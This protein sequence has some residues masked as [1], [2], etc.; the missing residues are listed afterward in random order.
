MTNSQDERANIRTRGGIVMRSTGRCKLCWQ[1]RLYLTPA[2]GKAKVT[3]RTRIDENMQLIPQP[4]KS[5]F[6]LSGHART[7]AHKGP[8]D[9]NATWTTRTLNM[10]EKTFNQ[11]GESIGEAPFALSHQQSGHPTRSQPII[12]L[13]D[14]PLTRSRSGARSHARSGVILVFVVVLLVLLAIM[15]TAYL[16]VV[17]MDRLQ[18]TGRGA[19]AN[20]NGLV[21]ATVLNQI[22]ERAKTLTLETLVR[23][24][25]AQAWNPNSTALTLDARYWRAPMNTPSLPV[26]YF[27]YVSPGT[28]SPWLS[29]ILP[30]VTGTGTTAAPYWRFIGSPVQRRDTSQNLLVDG[31]FSD[32]R[33]APG[34][35]APSTPSFAVTPSSPVTAYFGS[36]AANPNPA[37]VIGSVSLRNTAGTGPN[38]NRTYPAFA[39]SGTASGVPTGS[40]GVPF[41]AADADGDGIADSGLAP[42][43]LNPSGTTFVERYVAAAVATPA[44]S[45]AILDPANPGVAYYVGV[46]VVDNSAQINVQT[47]LSATSDVALGSTDPLVSLRTTG[48]LQ[49]LPNYGFFRSN[50]GFIELLESLDR[51]LELPLP[52]GTL[53]RYATAGPRIIDQSGLL[54]FRLGQFANPGS[55]WNNARTS[56]NAPW[57]ESTVPLP[58]KITNVGRQSLGDVLEQTSAS[59]LASPG[60]YV[61]AG[62]LQRVGLFDG[63]SAGASLAYRAGLISKSAVFGAIESVLIESTRFAAANFGG[64]APAVFD[65]FPANEVRLWFQ[66]SKNFPTNPAF[67]SVNPTVLNYSNTPNDYSGGAPGDKYLRSIR[68]LLTG[69]SGVTNFAPMRS[70]SA[71]TPGNPVSYT[72]PAFAASYVVPA[73]WTPANGPLAYPPMRV[74]V[75]VGSFQQLYRAFWQAMSDPINASL[76]VVV[77]PGETTFLSNSRRDV[78]ETRTVDDI[79]AEMLQLRTTIAALNTLDLRPEVRTAPGANPA[80]DPSVVAPGATIG[81]LSL[82]G[83]RT[84]A[85]FGNERQPFIIRVLMDVDLTAAPT[86]TVSRFAVVLYNPYD[87]DID[88]ATGDYKLLSVTRST[89]NVTLSTE[90]IA[91]TGNLAPRSLRVLGI[92]GTPGVAVTD[93]IATPP[94]TDSEIVLVRS[95]VTGVPM[96]GTVI[97]N[98]SQPNGPVPLDVVDLRRVG[99]NVVAQLAVLPTPPAYVRYQYKRQVAALNSPDRFT[100]VYAGDML[101]ANAAN[102][103]TTLFNLSTSATPF[104]DET[105]LA[106]A[107]T[108]GSVPPVNIPLQVF[109]PDFTGPTF[110]PSTGLGARFPFNVFPYK[111]PF[112]RDADLSAIPYIGSFIIYEAGGVIADFGTITTDAWYCDTLVTTGN[113][114]TKIAVGR[115]VQ[116]PG[117]T[118]TKEWVRALTESLTAVQDPVGD[119][120]PNTLVFNDV[121]GI[122]PF[123]SSFNPNASENQRIAGKININT[124]PAAVLA[125]LPLDVSAA[126]RSDIAVRVTAAEAISA[127]RDV[128]TTPRPFTSLADLAQNVSAV[129][130]TQLNQDLSTTTETVSVPGVNFTP[131][132]KPYFA[133]SLPHLSNLVTT[134]SDTFTVYITVQAWSNAGTSDARMIS[135]KRQS[136]IVDRSGISPLTTSLDNA[137]DQLRVISVE[138]Q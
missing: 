79:G 119:R 131:V 38:R 82:S 105:D 55:W 118:V 31:Y 107:T 3:L 44:N 6:P 17:R 128:N 122:A 100:C 120:V 115:F 30:G 95:Q 71:F 72:V 92:L 4:G 48:D 94:V 126:G 47:A 75:N 61:D 108:T 66:S 68:P 77:S 14:R 45:N 129:P 109:N 65:Y 78:P 114:P 99:Q 19:Q 24:I 80:E 62:Q 132:N 73:N 53:A 88:L 33:F 123:N 10:M 37:F 56:L 102:G 18:V 81:V 5:Y 2:P 58:T 51:T 12:I 42:V 76:P 70:L 116:T 43:V 111:S 91:L 112:A 22:S 29:P 103:P 86:Q 27:N 136:F 96:A 87:S 85:V 28:I 138:Q 1:T 41:I 89:G 11:P 110:D 124:A 26:T 35:S 84:A 34:F 93:T 57:N 106:A 15:G 63:S 74:G 50:A 32:P 125:M 137:V 127:Y 117:D 23:D 20:P 59:R 49:S 113:F 8:H 40:A 46:R 64:S 36:S 25:Y 9:E 7:S 135:E 104:P 98:W 130:N 16:S 133:R 134:Q 39:Q 13:S 121:A 90:L 101:S 60:S 69:Y 97:A 21:D 52:T 54:A 67:V 83:T